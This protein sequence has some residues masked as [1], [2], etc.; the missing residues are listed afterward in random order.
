MPL[1]LPL[2]ALILL[3][4]CVTPGQAQEADPA[5]TAAELEKVSAQMAKLQQTL[6]QFRGERSRLQSE[7]RTAEVTI[8]DV[9]KKISDI[10]R[11]L[12]QQQKELAALEAQSEQLALEKTRQQQLIA[13]QIGAAYQLGRQSKI[14][15]L[16]NQEKPD[17]ISRALTYYD[18]FNQARSEQ[19]NSYIALLQEIDQIKPA[20][21]AKTSNLREARLALT[22]ERNRLLAS[23][24]Q[25]QASLQQINAA[26][27][28]KDQELK[29]ASQ[30][31]SELEQLLSAVEEA[32]NN[33]TVPNDRQPFAKLKG[34]LPWPVQGKPANRFGSQRGAG[35][36]RWQGITIPASEGTE[37]KAIH[38]GRVVFA[39]WFRGSGLLIIIDHGDGFMSL[40]AHN[41]SLLREPGD[42]VG[43]G[44]IIATVGNSG[45]QDQASLYFEIRQDG[46]PTD[47][48]QW[49]RRA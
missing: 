17:Q 45:G 1:T 44:E 38:H 22:N 14:K 4:L 31:R 49:C 2:P 24:K 40:Y 26:I 33:I 37:V 21:A 20:I 42:W 19:I 5:R 15:L 43:S 9:Q 25:R 35:G 36:L 34:K 39:D 8:G 30:N 32:I 48:G 11:S 23:Q 12:A 41:Q 46:K 13:E 7:L 6:Q 28:S 16:L 29:Q 18:Y 27:S 10:Q 47:P 3:L